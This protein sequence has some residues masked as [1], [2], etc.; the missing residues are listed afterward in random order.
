MADGRSAA[1]LR[2]FSFRAARLYRKK[3]SLCVWAAGIP[4]AGLQGREA[5]VTCEPPEDN[6]VS[7][8]GTPFEGVEMPNR[9]A[10]AKFSFAAERNA[11]LLQQRRKKPPRMRIDEEGFITGDVGYVD[12]D[13]SFFIT[14]KRFVQIIEQQYVAPRQSRSLLKQCHARFAGGRRRFKEE[15]SGALIEHRIETLKQT[16]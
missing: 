6:K 1:S 5:C 15:T 12:E 3:L 2:F 9:K 8:I 16:H 10:T 11:Q 7:S 13:R 4:F 14:G